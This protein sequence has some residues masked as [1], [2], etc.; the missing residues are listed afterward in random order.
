MSIYDLSQ[1]QLR[2]RAVQ[3]RITMRHVLLLIPFVVVAVLLAQTIDGL[4]KPHFHQGDFGPG[5]SDDFDI[6]RLEYKL[7]LGFEYDVTAHSSYVQHRWL[8]WG[9]T[10]SR[11]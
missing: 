8:D 3:L 1:N 11:W 5:F 10:L 6:D 2:R 4:K 9:H 7:P